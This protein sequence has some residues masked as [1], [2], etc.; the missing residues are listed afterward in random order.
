LGA[1]CETKGAAIDRAQ[2]TMQRL[3]D[4]DILR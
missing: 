3:R 4:R 2:L 1:E